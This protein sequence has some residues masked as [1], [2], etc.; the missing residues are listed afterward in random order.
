MQLENTKLAYTS[1]SSDDDKGTR[2]TYAE[3]HAKELVEDIA[4]DDAAVKEIA[5]KHPK[6]ADQIPHLK[7]WLQSR[8]PKPKS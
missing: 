8:L 4:S 1:F 3:V 2:V 5:K 7:K 6:A